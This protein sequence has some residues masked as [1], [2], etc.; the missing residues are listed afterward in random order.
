MADVEI[1]KNQLSAFATDLQNK[2]NKLAQ[3]SQELLVKKQRLNNAQKKYNSEKQKLKLEEIQSLEFE[4]QRKFA[5]ERYKTLDKQRTDLDK[6]IKVSK[7]TLFKNTQDLF[8]LRE[9]EA[10]LYGEIQANVSACKN[11]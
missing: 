7:E 9:T 5:H 4:K 6:D 1:Q 3:M 10:N 11:Y 8:K 2:R